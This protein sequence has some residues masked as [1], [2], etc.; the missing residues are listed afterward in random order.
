[1]LAIARRPCKLQITMFNIDKHLAYNNNMFAMESFITF[2]K[3]CKLQKRFM[4]TNTLAYTNN[5][6]AKKLP[7]FYKKL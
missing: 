7:C 1:M 5:M 3:S 4:V 2:T 6:F